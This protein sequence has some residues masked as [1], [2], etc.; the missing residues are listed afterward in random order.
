MPNDSPRSPV[1]ADP[2]AASPVDRLVVAA[3]R[4][5]ADQVVELEL[6]RPDAGR[7][8]DWTPGAH[9]DLMLPNGLTRLYSLLG[10]PRDASSY[11]IA[12]QR[13]EHGDGGS[14]FVHDRLEVGDMVGFGGPR[15]NFRLV[16]AT[17]YAF[18]AGGIGITPI[19]PMLRAATVLGIDW[20]LLYLGRSPGALAYL[21]EL[22]GH[23]D[24]VQLHC[25]GSSGARADIDAWIA[26]SPSDAKVYACGPAGLLDA[27]VR[28]GANRRAGWVRVERFT[29]TASGPARATP[30][31][32]EIAGTDRTLIVE[33]G[34]TVV[35]TLRIA[36]FDVL[37]SCA[38]GVCGTCETEVLA[39]EP[40]HRDA[41]LDD[42][43]RARGNC[44]F[45]CVSRS[46]SD[47]LVIA[48]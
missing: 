32:L 20:R 37:T 26:E 7:L 42:A 5:V 38:R 29:A 25:S 44:F 22:A 17:S 4:V 31:A 45:P 46:R 8:P 15:N 18:V 3:R 19:L 43:E 28:A 10:D 2:A 34:T 9:L 24:R 13:E 16:P 23:G 27:V 40:D 36:G 30:F 1:S 21:A 35:E 6:Q 47:R 14:R 41:L 39:G 48:L 11:R 33:P 12:V